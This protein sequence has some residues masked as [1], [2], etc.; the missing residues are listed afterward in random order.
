MQ[1][2][3]Q[4]RALIA[5]EEAK[6]DDANFEQLKFLREKLERMEGMEQ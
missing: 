4:V 1:T 3:E 5:A 6:E 2:I